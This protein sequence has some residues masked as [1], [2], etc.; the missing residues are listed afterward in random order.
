MSDSSSLLDLIATSQG[1][2]EATANELFDAGSTATAYGRRAQTNAGLTWGY[3]GTRYGGTSIAN[4]TNLCGASTTTYMVANLSTGAVSF[5]TSTT[6]WNDSTNYG[7]CY[8]I[9]T[10]TDSITSYEDHR[11]G[12]GGMFGSGAAGGGSVSSVDASGGVQTASGSAITSSGTIRGA[13]VINAQTGTSYAV[14]SGDRGKHVTLS[15][16]ASIAATIA[17]AGTTGFEDGYFTFIENIGVGAVT[18]TPTTSTINGAATLVLTSGTAALLFS[19]GT[20]YRAFVINA[21]GIPVN[22]QTGT[23]YTYLSGDRNKLVTHTNVSAIA[24]T[25]PQATGAFGAGW[26]MWVQNRGAGTLTITPTTSTIDGAASLALTTGQGTLIV[27]DGTN[28]FTMR[29][30]GSGGITALTGDVTASGT[31]SVVATIANDAVTNAKLANV[32]TQTIK[33][34]TTA[35]TGDPEDLTAAQAAAVL[36]GDGLTVDLAGFRGIPQNSKSAAYTTVA[37]DAGKHIFHPSADTTARTFTID[38]NANVAYPVGTAITFI[39]QNS[40]GVITIAITSDTMRLAG[41]GTTG[42]RTLAA[43]GIATAIK[44][45]STEWIISGTGLS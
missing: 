26:A 23:S 36:Q 13:H 22:A 12:P 19:D 34:R 45:A 6:N 4:G 41:A 8:K 28:Y 21:P 15:N 10:G 16:A 5:A 38:S 24:G 33:G 37:A 27:S 9:V 11:F 7:R 30:A 2:K 39:N 35:S 1:N 17:Q 14:V 31:G 40:A 42:S 44:V 18:L 43:N 25:L 3:Y 20:N 29:G 32:A